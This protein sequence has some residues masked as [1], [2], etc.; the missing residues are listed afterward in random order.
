MEVPHFAATTSR[1]QCYTF[2]RNNKSRHDLSQYYEL[3]MILVCVC[4]CVS[5]RNMCVFR[6]LDGL[7]A[8]AALQGLHV[9]HEPRKGDLLGVL[10]VAGPRLELLDHDLVLVGVPP[11]EGGPGLVD[12]VAEGHADVG[13]ADGDE[14]GLVGVELGLDGGGEDVE[15]ADVGG[16]VVVVGGAVV[17]VVGELVAE[18]LAEVVEGGL[19]G[20]VVGAAGEGDEGQ[21]GGD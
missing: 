17:V 2:G 11:V 10:E 5:N 1:A 21:A 20:A 13:L 6:T 3:W 7:A 12:E 14:L 19:G 8:L 16:A 4:V 15:D 18:G 9:V